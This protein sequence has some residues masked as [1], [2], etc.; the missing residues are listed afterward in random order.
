[1]RNLG[2]VFTVIKN[3]IQGTTKSCYQRLRLMWSATLVGRDQ[4]A[5][6]W[7][8]AGHFKIIR[9][10]LVKEFLEFNRMSPSVYLENR[11]LIRFTKAR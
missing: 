3:F 8:V 7:K 4:P 5:R 2:L 6:N 10:Y 9:R 1:M 11:E